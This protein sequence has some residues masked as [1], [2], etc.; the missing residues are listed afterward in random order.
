M[1]LEA[2]R[3]VIEIE[4]EAVAALAQRLNEEFVKAVRF[5]TEC[6]G[7]VVVTGVGK[8][9]AIGRKI[10]GTLASYGTPAVFLHASEGLHGDLGMVTEG[11]V[12]L[13]ISYSGRTEDI[14]NILPVVKAMGVPVVAMTG[15]L[16]SLLATSSDAVLDVSV[17]REACPLN[18][19]PTASTTATLAMGDALAVAVMS[20]RRVSRDDFARF[21]PGGTLGKGLSLK[22][23]ELMRTG[24]RVATVLL[25]GTVRDVLLA[26]TKAQA[27]A[28]AV[29][30]DEGTLQGIVTDGDVRRHLVHADPTQAL[31][32]PVSEVMTRT[33][34]TAPPSQ[35]A[36]EALRLMEENVIDDL[37]VVDDEGRLLGM[38]D[39]QDLLRAG[40]M[41]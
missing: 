35:P 31:Q 15:N 26:V 28:A 24:S 12:V 38:L 29:V 33:A 41:G 5:L 27:G 36:L 13:A 25:S 10:A 20:E 23:E 40:V 32:S 2:A 19:A 14:I 21:H 30:N 6:R 7:R 1:P 11:D 34:Y 17:A 37:P 4:A 39:V 18:L 9:G 3:R 8:S 16:K 22:V